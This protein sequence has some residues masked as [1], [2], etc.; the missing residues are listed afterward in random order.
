M[1]SS[2]RRAISSRSLSVA[3][4]DLAA[5][6]PITY[7]IKEAVGM[8]WMTLT[9]LGERCSES[10]YCGIVSQSQLMPAFIDSYGIASV[11]VIVNIER[12]RNS[13]LHGAKPK[14]QLPKTSEVT[15]CH[16]EMVQ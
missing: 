2:S 16:P 10:M 1:P 11:R 3:G 4:R 15:P 5:S 13:R 14:P 9:P 8:Y 12:S 6:N 7:V